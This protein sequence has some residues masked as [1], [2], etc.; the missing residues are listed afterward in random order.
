MIKKILAPLL[1][2]LILSSNLETKNNEVIG[3]GDKNAQIVIKVFSSLTCPHCAQFHEKVIEDLKKEYVDQNKVRFE[4]H[5]F[6]L[7]L[8]ALNAE[9]ILRCTSGVEKS[10]QLLSE[11]YK[12]Q[13]LWAVGSDINVINDSIKKIG[14]EFGLKESNMNKCLKDN[15]TQDV[16]LSERIKAQKNYKIESTPTVFINNKKY[17]GKVNYE[18]FRK[19]I[20]RNL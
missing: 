3:V 10:F 12:K 14:K 9:K 11:I 16:I 18:K 5:S 13:N 15:D 20:E 17:T 4:H 2:L 19:I 6:P 1:F 7:D 8:A